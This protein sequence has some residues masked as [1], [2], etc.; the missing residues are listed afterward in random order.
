MSDKL[1]G[2][3]GGLRPI[4]HARIKRCQWTAIE[5][6]GISFGV[7]DSEYC[8]EDGISGWVEFKK[9]DGWRVPTLK[10]NPL[11]IAWIARRA[12]LGGR[13]WVAVRRV[14]GD[15]DNLYLVNGVWVVKLAEGGILS[16]PV[17][18]FDGGECGWDWD[19]IRATLHK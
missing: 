11:Q 5:T 17:T 3:D 14:K 7:P 1:L 6:G 13:V 2:R 4:F 18:R 12:R 10:N 8:F 9:A 16:V 19:Q 15:R